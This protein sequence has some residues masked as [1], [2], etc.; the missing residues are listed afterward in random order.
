MHSALIKAIGCM[1]G[2]IESYAEKHQLPSM[3]SKCSQ[4]GKRLMNYWCFS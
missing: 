2:V 3:T 4:A 1:S